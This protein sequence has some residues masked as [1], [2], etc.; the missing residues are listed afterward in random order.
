M[1]EKKVILAGATYDLLIEMR[2]KFLAI[3]G[4]ILLVF[5]VFFLVY[6]TRL[7]VYYAG[8]GT[9]ISMTGKVVGGLA[10][11]NCE[12]P[13][14]TI[15]DTIHIRVNSIEP[16]TVR[17]DSPNG[18]TV[19]QWQ[20][21]TVDADYGVAQVGF[22]HVYVTQPSG[23]F[24]YGEVSATAPAYVHPA[25]MYATIPLSLG[26]ITVL[27]SQNRRKR[28]LYFEKVLFEQNVGGRW[29]F[30]EWAVILSF[31]SEAPVFVP[32]Y[33]WLYV[34]LISITV[35]GVFSSIALAYIKIYLSTEGLLI[36]A[37]FLNFFRHYAVNQIYGYTVA[38]QK[39]QQWFF[40]R[41]LPSFRGKKEDEVTVL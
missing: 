41:P 7:P 9:G 39:K 15:P 10:P 18:T 24:V 22:W 12:V 19:A 17:I 34:V 20:N 37:P 1:L 6:G 2:W 38:Q 8:G 16:V 33:P 28:A 21:E 3:I 29:V 25:L 35:F 36:E 4:T 27:Y 13:I 26:S 31:I 23:Y 11:G 5:G 32:S 40:L 30:L 14:I